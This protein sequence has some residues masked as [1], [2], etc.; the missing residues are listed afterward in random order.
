MSA[1]IGQPVVEQHHIGLQP[2]RFGQRILSGGGFA[3]D[4][5]GRVEVSNQTKAHADDWMV[6]HEQNSDPGWFRHVEQ[7][8]QV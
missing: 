7:R 3:D 4:F 5:D 6:V 2:T 1:E 8:S